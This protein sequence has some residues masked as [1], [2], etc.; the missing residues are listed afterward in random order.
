[1][2]VKFFPKEQSL[3]EKSIRILDNRDGKDVLL[4]H[5]D[6]FSLSFSFSAGEMHRISSLVF[7]QFPI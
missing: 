6:V 7:V 2:L 5:L 3:I 1:M 4:D